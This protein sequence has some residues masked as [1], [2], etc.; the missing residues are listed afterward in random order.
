VFSH[1]LLIG[2]WE[3][4]GFLGYSASDEMNFGGGANSIYLGW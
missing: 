4:S 1:N 2:R 3:L